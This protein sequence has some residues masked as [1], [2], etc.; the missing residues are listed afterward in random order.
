[1]TEAREPPSCLSASAEGTVLRLRVVPGASKTEAQGLLGDRLKLRL[2]AP[3]VE[4]KANEAA[5]EWA[6]AAFGLK[7]REVRFLRGE[8][9]R[10]KDFLLEGLPLESGRRALE[11]LGIG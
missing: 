5:L 1:M 10:E 11:R 9:S 4:G 7:R 3:P 6:A 2:Q 8:K